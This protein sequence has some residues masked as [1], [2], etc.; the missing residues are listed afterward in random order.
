[1]VIGESCSVSLRLANCFRLFSIA[2][3]QFGF[4][5][6]LWAVQRIL[7]HHHIRIYFCPGFSIV[8]R[9]MNPPRNFLITIHYFRT[10]Y[11]ETLSV[12]R[13]SLSLSWS[14]FC[15]FS[16]IKRVVGEIYWHA[17]SPLKKSF[18][19]W[20]YIRDLSICITC[21]ESTFKYLQFGIN[22]TMRSASSWLIAPFSVPSSIISVLAWSTC[23]ASRQKWLEKGTKRSG[24]HRS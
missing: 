23:L 24:D 18:K 1:M 4:L 16:I 8:D 6:A 19:I 14:V 12:I 20:I 17:W 10:P 13:L 3:H 21:S 15:D 22:V 9:A 2:W 7:E 11:N 5:F